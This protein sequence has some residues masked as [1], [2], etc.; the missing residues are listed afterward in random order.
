[1]TDGNKDP[2]LFKCRG[3]NTDCSG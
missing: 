2:G 3:R 1:V